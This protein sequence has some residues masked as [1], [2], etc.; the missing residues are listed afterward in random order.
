M[1]NHPNRSKVSR[2]VTPHTPGPWRWQGE[3]DLKPF[4]TVRDESNRIIARCLT[5]DTTRTASGFPSDFEA[6][7]A[8]ARLIAAAPD[9]LKLL[10]EVLDWNEDDADLATNDT[11]F[12]LKNFA[13]TVSNRSAA[14]R[15]ILI[16]AK[17]L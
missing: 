16:K 4:A 7:K 5:Q 15:A 8:N 12:R 9:M 17:G 6:V 10:S 3:H 13:D 14:L 2:R 1:I 11:A